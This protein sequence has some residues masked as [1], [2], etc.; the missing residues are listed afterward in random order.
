MAPSSMAPHLRARYV[1]EIALVH[2]P[3]WRLAL[4]GQQM[5]RA[6][7]VARGE[8]DERLGV[9][10]VPRLTG[11]HWRRPVARMWLSRRLT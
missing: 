6:L 9:L 3:G 11:V 10:D 4:A 7:D 5:G 2:P 8:A 1:A